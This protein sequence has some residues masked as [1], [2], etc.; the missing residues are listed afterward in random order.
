MTTEPRR[1][2]PATVAKVLVA[3]LASASTL[4]L[5]AGMAAT[6][7]PDVSAP[8]GS[9]VTVARGVVVGCTGPGIPAQPAPRVDERAPVRSRTRGS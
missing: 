7:A 9:T 2:P 4:G 5:T 8:C 3:G 1:R 6:S